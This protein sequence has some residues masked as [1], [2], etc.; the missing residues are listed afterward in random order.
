MLFFWG[1]A[2]NPYKRFRRTVI[3]LV[4]V[5]CMG[6]PISLLV[7]DKSQDG[8][9]APSV[10][11]CVSLVATT[12]VV[13][14]IVVTAG[15]LIR[16]MK[17][18]LDDFPVRGRL[19]RP[20]VIKNYRS[21]FAHAHEVRAYD[22]PLNLLADSADHRDVLID[23]LSRGVEC[24]FLCDS[25]VVGNQFETLK[26]H[27]DEKLPQ[28][29]SRNLIRRI[30]MDRLHT[31]V[32]PWPEDCCSKRGCPNE[33]KCKPWE[34]P[35]A[36]HCG[37]EECGSTNCHLRPRNP[38]APYGDVRGLSFFLI[39]EELIDTVLLYPYGLLEGNLAA[40][41]HAIL[42]RGQRE[43]NSLYTAL[44][45]TFTR[46]WSIVT[47]AE[48]EKAEEKKAEEVIGS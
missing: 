6:L 34:N 14:V 30:G 21:V 24:Q 40:P 47:R 38:N 5:L 1:K 35:G 37:R 41:A 45:E 9:K 43:K 20:S 8:V 11:F 27:L 13:A 32:K 25:I 22:P 26:K 42:I 23:L 18:K 33:N 17:D 48:K 36:C 44:E 4:L 31:V 28:A 10:L 12:L 19:I 39:R 2:R 15:P 46:R 16:E 3:L 29:K 7:L